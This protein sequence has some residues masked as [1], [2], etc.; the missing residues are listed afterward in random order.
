[1]RVFWI[2][3]IVS[4][5]L[6]LL[7]FQDVLG[8]MLRTGQVPPGPEKS[9]RVNIR[10]VKK[11]KPKP[12]V[13]AV[14]PKPKKVVKPKV[15]K[16]PK[17]QPKP[18]VKPQPKPKPKV[19]KAPPP[20]PVKK[21]SYPKARKPSYPK[22]RPKISVSQNKVPKAKPRAS[23]KR[24]TA[25]KSSKSSGKRRVAVQTSDVGS[26]GRVGVSPSETEWR[27]PSDRTPVEVPT[28]GDGG[29]NNSPPPAPAPKPVTPP[30]PKAPP[31]PP[32]PKAFP[33][34][35]VSQKPKSD[36]R[37]ATSKPRARKAQISV[38][39][40][41]PP[42]KFR[43]EKLQGRIKVRFK[44]NAD[45]SFDVSLSDTSGNKEFDNFVLEQIRRTAV[46]EPAIDED[47]KPKR[48]V[49]RRPVEINIQ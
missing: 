3:L 42:A 1:M 49:M 21:R 2:C 37:V 19:A 14:K 16:K 47:G 4:I 15:V 23:A 31:P 24:L 9:Q 11:K 32:K 18:K 26:G 27:P 5:T 8:S 44:I 17:V 13:V 7:F 39:S 45:G 20:K 43:R 33:K 36:K 25:K 38:P 30:A 29:V 22:A 28:S 46:V 35:P 41:D 12:K 34:P 48:S 40:I 6:H 10:L